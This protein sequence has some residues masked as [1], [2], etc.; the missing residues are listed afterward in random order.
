LS[1]RGNVATTRATID[2]PRWQLVS[3]TELV[4]DP[5]QE[6]LV[7]F[8]ASGPLD[9]PSRTKVGGRLLRSGVSKVQRQVTNP[10]QKLLPGLLGGR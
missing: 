6:P 4:D 5:Q 7:T 10:I 1:G 2:L 8:D 9:A 3:A